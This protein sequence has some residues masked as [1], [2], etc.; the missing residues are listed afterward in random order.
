[1]FAPGDD[2][3]A[4]P[5]LVDRFHELVQSGG[6]TTLESGSSGIEIYRRDGA[7]QLGQANAK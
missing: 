5:E 1:V 6:W 2:S 3:R 4:D 7:A